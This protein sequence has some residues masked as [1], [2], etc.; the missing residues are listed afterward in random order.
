V[1]MGSINVGA[2]K[3]PMW[4]FK[5]LIIEGYKKDLEKKKAKQNEMA[6]KR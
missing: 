1:A 5:D 4:K 2:Q 3:S 6:S